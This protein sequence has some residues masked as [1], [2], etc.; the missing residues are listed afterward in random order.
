MVPTLA[1]AEDATT[2]E[3]Q[4]RSRA[5][6]RGGKLL[7]C[8]GKVKLRAARGSAAAFQRARGPSARI[9]HLLRRR[10]GLEATAGRRRRRLAAA[11]EEDAKADERDAGDDA[12]HD[13]DDGAG[14]DVGAVRLR[15]Q[16]LPA[17]L[18]RARVLR[19]D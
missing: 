1:R 12:E 4:W 16:L 5:H 19:E 9:G 6:E 3:R 17:V 11:E 14:R 18:G 15:L 7:S 13:G 2:H 8:E 10:D